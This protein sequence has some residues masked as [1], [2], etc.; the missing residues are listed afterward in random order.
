MQ[1][2]TRCRCAD[3]N[4]VLSICRGSAEMTVQMQSRCK[5]AEVMQRWWC[6]GGAEVVA[7][8]AEVAVQ[9]WWQCMQRWQCRGGAEVVQRWA[10]VQQG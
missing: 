4:E 2:C 9:R 3:A 8:H 5:G 1:R 6:K 10:L 7:V